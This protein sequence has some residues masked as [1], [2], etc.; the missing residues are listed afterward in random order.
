[1]QVRRDRLMVQRQ[2]GFD[3]AR[4]AGSGFEVTKIGFDGP[5]LQRVRSLSIRSKDIAERADFNGI[6]EWGAGAMRFDVVDGL[7]LQ[8][9]GRQGGP[10]QSSLG[11]PMGDRQPTAGA[12]LVYGRS[13]N[14]RQY[15]IVVT[16]RIAQSFQR[17]APTTFTPHH[18][19]GAR[20]ERPSSAAGGQHLAAREGDAA[21]RG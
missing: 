15:E 19:L 11:G 1:M 2:D 9:S 6:A 21:N 20:V 16:L 10:E 3:E 12:V 13:G 7:G 5:H 4:D 17:H 8:T 18:A 14:H